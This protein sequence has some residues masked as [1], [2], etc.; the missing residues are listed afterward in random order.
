METRG[1]L[2]DRLSKIVMIA[3]FLFLIS[4]ILINYINPSTGYEISIYD[5]VPFW[6]FPIL[7]ISIALSGFV[8]IIGIKIKSN[9]RI[10]IGFIGLFISKLTI[11]Y[12]PTIRG[13]VS[14]SGDNFTHI[15]YIS[16]LISDGFIN[17]NFY[18]FTHIFLASIQFITNGRIFTIV[19]LSTSI[20]SLLFVISVYILSN[21]I[22]NNKYYS[23]ISTLSVSGIFLLGGYELFVMPNGWSILLSPLIIFVILKSKYNFGFSVIT[24]IFL[25]II[26]FYH[27]LTSVF[28][29]LFIFVY[30]IFSNID[31]NLGKWVKSIAI[32][33]KFNFQKI[34]IISCILVG[35]VLSFNTFEIKLG[36]IAKS[37][38]YGTGNSYLDQIGAKVNQT[39]LGLYDL[40]I[41]Y[42]LN[43][44][45]GFL[46]ILINLLIFIY[47]IYNYFICKSSNYKKI[48]PYLMMVIICFGIY[49]LYFFASLPGL[50]EIAAYRFLSYSY[51]FTP[52]PLAF[53]LMDQYKKRKK[54]GKKVLISLGIIFG[55]VIFPA[56][57]VYGFFPSSIT[58]QP[59]PQISSE[60]I[61]TYNWLF[62]DDDNNSHYYFILIAPY[63]MADGINGKQ[64]EI[65]HG[66]QSKTE[67][68]GNHFNSIE[69]NTNNQ[70]H[71]GY[72]IVSGKD[73][74][75]QDLWKNVGRFDEN[76]FDRLNYYQSVNKIYSGNINEIWYINNSTEQQS[77]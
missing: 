20:F 47:V 21:T 48:I 73:L 76:D 37:F 2:I 6:V 43:E 34:L 7:I 61:C 56:I 71:S 63:R 45:V 40:V 30:I 23:I 65:D 32:S 12:L 53:F 55:L 9:K 27:P 75:Y 69:N 17:N 77:V 58:Y 62:S 57:S 14:F 22:F 33:L 5:A 1:Q 36:R 70:T 68:I 59:S 51:I 11:L 4:I 18:P 60:D 44:G 50:G 66:I 74:V 29:I 64:W 35:W 24:I 31:Y 72:L 46:F 8:V 28:L 25:S 38:I 52:I 10:I 42:I 19:G 3:V 54:A 26:T 15:G 16:D 41:E 49:A 67:F 39:G 13:Y